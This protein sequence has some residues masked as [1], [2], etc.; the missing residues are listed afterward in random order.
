MRTG[1]KRKIAKSV[2]WT[3]IYL[4][5]KGMIEGTSQE[6]EQRGRGAGKR[7]NFSCKKI[8]A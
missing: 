4:K 3:V 7:C 2:H 1:H 6:G 8:S 5:Q